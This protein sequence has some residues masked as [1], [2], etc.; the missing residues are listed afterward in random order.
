MQK[1]K[2]NTG[3]KKDFDEHMASND[4]KSVSNMKGAGNLLVKQFSHKG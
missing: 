1:K 4:N 2:D 3:G